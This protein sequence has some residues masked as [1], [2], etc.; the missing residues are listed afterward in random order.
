LADRDR[1]LAVEVFL[2]QPGSRGGRIDLL[3]FVHHPQAHHDNRS[4]GTEHR[5]TDGGADQ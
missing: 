3:V 2:H 1:H 4:N 5:G